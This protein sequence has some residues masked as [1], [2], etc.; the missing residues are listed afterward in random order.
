MINYYSCLSC[1]FSN[2]AFRSVCC[3]MLQL[4]LIK[5]ITSNHIMPKAILFRQFFNVLLKQNKTHV[6]GQ[7]T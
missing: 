6:F 4:L 3:L 1:M 7:C 5:E 2:M